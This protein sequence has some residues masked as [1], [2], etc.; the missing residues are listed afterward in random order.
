[1]ENAK[2]ELINKAFQLGQKYEQKFTGCA[3]TVIAAI[4]DTLD[5]WNDDVFKS[6]SGLADGLGL[7]GDG[8]CGAL[9][10]ASMIIGYLFGRDRKHIRDMMY[11]MKSYKLAKELH[12]HYV[13]KYG[14]CRCYD[15]QKALMGRTYNLWDPEEMKL[16]FKSGMMEHCSKVVGSMA[17][18]AVEL[19]LKQ[20]INLAKFKT[21]NVP[22]T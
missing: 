2:D 9:M 18:Y 14:S 19:I 10:G 6:A 3:Q 17:A 1:M 4:F 11:P 16:A 20:K 15:V 22:V 21:K 7:T 13:Q 8:T 12:D 5:I